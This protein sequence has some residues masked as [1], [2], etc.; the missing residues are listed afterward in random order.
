MKMVRLSLQKLLDKNTIMKII[1]NK[2]LYVALFTC[3]NVLA[4]AD[5]PPIPGGGGTGSSGTGSP[6]SPIDMYIYVL[7]II[8]IGCAIYFAKKYTK[9][10]SK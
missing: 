2:Y 9:Q 3:I 4:F 1:L 8:A 6:A 7:G 5:T 10:L